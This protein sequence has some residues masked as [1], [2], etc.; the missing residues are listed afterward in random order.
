MVASLSGVHT[1]PQILDLDRNEWGPITLTTLVTARGK[2]NLEVMFTIFSSFKLWREEDWDSVTLE[3]HSKPSLYQRLPDKSSL[4][5]QRTKYGSSLCWFVKW[6]MET[7]WVHYLI[8]ESLWKLLE[9]LG[10]HKALLMVQLSITVDNLLSRSK[11]TLT[12]LTGRMGQGIS[13]AVVWDKKIHISTYYFPRVPVKY[14]ADK[15]PGRKAGPMF[16]I[17]HITPTLTGVLMSAAVTMEN[18]NNMWISWG[19]H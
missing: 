9:T 5:M 4:H 7:I 13:N 8:E 15:W 12:S 14:K 1:T 3:K 19:T 6:I 10:T 18:V 17:S 2:E 11:A 16:I